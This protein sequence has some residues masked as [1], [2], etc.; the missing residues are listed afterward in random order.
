MISSISPNHGVDS[1]SVSY[2]QFNNNG[3]LTDENLNSVQSDRLQD[4]TKKFTELGSK[5]GPSDINGKYTVDNGSMMV[6]AQNDW[7]PGTAKK[8]I[9]S[10]GLSTSPDDSD[11]S[12]SFKNGDHAVTLIDKIDEKPLPDHHAR[13]PMNAFLIFCKRHRGIVRERYPNLENR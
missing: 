10:E 1:Y 2:G 5:M 7:S 12:G 9:K 3:Y 4:V 11:S 13:R 8:L 6:D